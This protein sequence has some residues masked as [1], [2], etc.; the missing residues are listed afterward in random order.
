MTAKDTRFY[1]LAAVIALMF[2]GQ[3]FYKS[4]VCSALLCL[5]SIP[6]RRLYE[7]YLA[8]KRRTALGLSFRDLLYSMSASFSTGRQM[9]EALKEGLLAMRLIY[10]D[11]APIVRELE[12]MTARLLNGRDDEESTLN[13]FANRSRSD[14]IRNFIDAYFIC[15]TTGGDM[16]AMVVR[17]AG[18]IIDK[19]EIRKEL[20]TLTAQK[21][22]EANIL[23]LLPIVMLLLLQILSPDYV[24]ALYEG[25]TGRIV[26]TAALV[27]TALSYAWSLRL[28]RFEM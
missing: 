21:R 14:D 27:L 17:A 15:R 20:R 12:Y 19:I 7:R 5:L 23:L 25:L 2:V 3:V 13:D 10:S 1:Y 11:D 18:M 26:M 4:L 24:A 28:T 9:P 6:C 22:M 16:E 8:E